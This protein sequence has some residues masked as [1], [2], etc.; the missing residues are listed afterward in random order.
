MSPISR[1]SLR[2]PLSLYHQK[3]K[4]MRMNYMEMKMLLP[5]RMEE[6]KTNNREAVHKR[7]NVWKSIRYLARVFVL[8]LLLGVTALA[9]YFL[10]YVSQ[11]MD[12]TA[13][14]LDIGTLSIPLFAAWSCLL[15]VGI[16]GLLPVIMDTI[17]RKGGIRRWEADKHLLWQVIVYV[18]YVV[19]LCVLL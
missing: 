15:G 19:L 9:Y 12:P 8:C 1:F 13:G 7:T 3:T 18:G 16:A 4:N 2:T 11:R 17:G 6:A 5:S 14:W 10:G